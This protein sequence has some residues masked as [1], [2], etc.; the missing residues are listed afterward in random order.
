MTY[1]KYFIGFNL[2][3]GIG[4]AKFIKLERHFGNMKDAWH[5]GSK[6]LSDA[7]LDDKSITSILTQWYRM[8]LDDELAMM[9]IK[10]IVKQ[11]AGMNY[12]LSRQ[13]NIINA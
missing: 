7:G 9:G 5:A 10:G 6:E 2:T 12:I 11:V 8:S 1:L 4:R 13:S 3:P